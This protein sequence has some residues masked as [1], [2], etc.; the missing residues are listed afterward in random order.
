MP[1]PMKKG[2]NSKV[3]ITL[4]IVVALLILGVVA[5]VTLGGESTTVSATGTTNINVKPDFAT[6][7]F[8]VETEGENSS[9]ASNKNSEVVN[10]AKAALMDLGFNE[11]QISTEN[12]NIR[13]QYDYS[14]DRE[15]EISGYIASHALKVKIPVENRNNI[16][17]AI[18]AGANAGA[19]INHINFEIEE[20]RKSSLKTDAIEQATKDAKEKAKALA[21]GS[22]NRL[23]KL[24]SL[25]S[26]SFNYQPWRAY[27]A[28][29][30]LD[31]GG[32]G[33]AEIATNINPS[34][35]DVSASVE[36]VFRVK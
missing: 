8:N 27:E 13:P 30:S 26:T 24:K 14:R 31:S 1:L 5:T 34:E 18:D 4:I 3:L 9:E 6:V 32:K 11:S 17:E 16:G 23:G 33:G 10:N 19:R 15:R 35:R 12:Y 28:K 7:Y 22:G 25:S 20:D 36:A 2:P 29:G 21:E